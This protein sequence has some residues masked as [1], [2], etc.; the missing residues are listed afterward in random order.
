MRESELFRL[1]PNL[2]V[3]KEGNFDT[4][5]CRG[6]HYGD[7]NRDWSCPATGKATPIATPGCQLDYIWNQLKPQVLGK[8]AV[9]L[10]EVGRPTLNLGHAFRCE[11][12][13]K[14]RG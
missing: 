14:D 9:G 3:H 13:L 11:P 4:V 5:H 10:S 2:I 12:T 6:E 1:G 7:M 8:P